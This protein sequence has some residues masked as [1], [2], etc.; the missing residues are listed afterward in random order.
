MKVTNSEDDLKSAV[1][2]Y[3]P[4]VVEVDH[5][6]S[7]FQVCTSERIKLHNTMELFPETRSPL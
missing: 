3:G 1:A 7:S 6:H 4:V 2:L 5:L